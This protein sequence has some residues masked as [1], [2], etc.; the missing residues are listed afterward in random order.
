MDWTCA[1]GG[2][3]QWQITRRK[4]P[5]VFQSDYVV[6]WGPAPGSG[7]DTNGT[8][9]E[10]I[11]PKLQEVFSANYTL[12]CNNPLDLATFS[13]E[14]WPSEYANVNFYTVFKPGS[15]QYG[16]LDWQA[17]IAG[18]EYAQGKPML[19]ALTSIFSGS[20]DPSVL[21]DTSPIIRRT[22]VGLWGKAEMRVVSR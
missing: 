2:G 21:S 18:V 7:M 4:K 22:P 8:F 14:P 13:V 10:Q 5:W 20:R 16:R 6:K 3:E 11:L 12:N 9:S 1:C 19:F 17:W 15:E